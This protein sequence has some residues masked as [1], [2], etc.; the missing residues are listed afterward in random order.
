MY[1]T[2]D[3]IRYWA[4]HLHSSVDIQQRVIHFGSGAENDLLIEVP[5]GEIDPRA[6]IVVTVGLDESRMNSA[7]ADSDPKIGLWDGTNNNAQKI[8][9]VSNYGNYL[10]CHAVNSTARD[11]ELVPTDTPFPSV[12]KLTFIPFYRYAACETAQLG[13]YINTG[14]FSFQLD[15][16]K[17]LFLIVHREGPHE[18]MFFRYF[19]VEIF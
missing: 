13:G 16:T 10:P 18:E 8:R 1:L 19:R 3:N 4:S 17:P 5:L 15:T 12:V 7:A 11:G 2:P 9:D 14:T 6:T